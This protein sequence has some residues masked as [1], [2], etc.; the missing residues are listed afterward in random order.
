MNLPPLAHVPSAPALGDK[1]GEYCLQLVTY[2]G[3]IIL[4]VRKSVITI[5]SKHGG[6]KI[7]LIWFNNKEIYEARGLTYWLYTFFVM[8][9]EN[10]LTVDRVELKTKTYVANSK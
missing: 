10:Y 1:F 7:K 5:D 8:S 6:R 9:V 2:T 4:L 3:I